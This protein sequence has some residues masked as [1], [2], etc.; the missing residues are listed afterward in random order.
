MRDGATSDVDAYTLLKAMPEQDR[1]AVR[2][3]WWDA[4][5]AASDGVTAAVAV[6]R[7]AKQVRFLIALGAGASI[8]TVLTLATLSG[9]IWKVAPLVVAATG[10]AWAWYAVA[11]SRRNMGRLA[12]VADPEAAATRARDLRAAAGQGPS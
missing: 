9:S 12:T 8:Y 2:D 5:P 11:R 10:A 4:G 6:N 3:A 7:A 1:A